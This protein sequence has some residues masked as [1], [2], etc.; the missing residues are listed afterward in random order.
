MKKKWPE[1]SFPSMNEYSIYINRKYVHKWYEVASKDTSIL[2]HTSK[3]SI[4][5]FIDSFAFEF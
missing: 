1:K 2:Y 4:T 3:Y 5:S